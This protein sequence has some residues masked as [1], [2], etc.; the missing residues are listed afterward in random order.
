LFLKLSSV[1]FRLQGKMS[2]LCILQP[3]PTIY[4]KCPDKIGIGA[5]NVLELVSGMGRNMHI[6]R[7]K[8][9]HRENGSLW[10]PG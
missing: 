4:I 8:P 10:R 1:T 3:I 9:R 6:I 5:R 7:R 2:V